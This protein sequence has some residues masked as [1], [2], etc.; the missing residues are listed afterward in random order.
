MEVI[1]AGLD[2]ALDGFDGLIREYMEP[3]M[4]RWIHQSANELCPSWQLR[5]TF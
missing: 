3:N 5:E 2:P 4:S 1:A